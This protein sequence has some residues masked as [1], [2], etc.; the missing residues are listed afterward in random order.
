MIKLTIDGKNIQTDKSSTILKA[1]KENGIEIPTL[2]YHEGLSPLANCRL[3][4]VE[5][6]QKGRTKVVTSCNYVVEEGMK[7][8]TK[9]DNLIAIRK[10]IVELLMV[11]SSTCCTQPV[12]RATRAR[13]LP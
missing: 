1:A 2:C 12:S 7:V 9:T 13:R 4:V 5:V 10:M 6:T 8:E 11:G 3:C